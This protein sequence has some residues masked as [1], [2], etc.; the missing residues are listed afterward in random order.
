MR[1]LT[2]YLRSRRVPGALAAATGCLAAMWALPVAFSDGGEVTP[3][4]VALTLVLLIS[5]LAV[6]LAGP[7]E[8]LE[9]T[10]A[11][12]WP[13]R[14]VLHL[15]A[16]FAVVLTLM[17]VTAVTATPFGPAELVVRDA[18][19]LLGLTALGTAALGADRSWFLPLGWTIPVV[20]YPA[21]GTTAAEVATWQ[22]QAPG[23]LPSAATATMFAVGGL[24][25]FATAGAARRAP[26][27]AAL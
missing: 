8:A 9:R 5:V 2:L 4:T 12:C 1:W 14:R 3:R 7:D 26:A 10:G 16:V 20:I 11:L 19:G 25:A 13:P 27:E 15:L 17:S 18:A 6:T 24:I 22:A 21:S 23:N